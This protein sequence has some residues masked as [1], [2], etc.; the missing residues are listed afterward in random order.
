MDSTP[1]KGFQMP[2]DT[3][4]RDWI[5]ASRYSVVQRFFLGRLERLVALRGAPDAHLEPWQ[6]TLVHRAIYSTYCDCV[7][8]GI[9]NAAQDVLHRAESAPQSSASA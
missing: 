7:E 4:R 6:S 5:D 1:E 3:A 9:A 2:G 8:Q